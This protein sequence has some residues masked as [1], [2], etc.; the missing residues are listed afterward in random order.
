MKHIFLF[1]IIAL[2][3]FGAVIIS[4]V[5]ELNEKKTEA[6]IGIEKIDIGMSGFVVHKIDEEHRTILKNCVVTNYDEVAKRATIKMSEYKFVEN[7]AL[8]KGKWEV[9]V[10]DDVVLAFGYNRGLLIAPNEEIYYR[11]TK[12]TKLQWVHPDIFASVLS[13]M[14]HPTPMKSDFIKMS[15][16]MSVGLVFVYLD[17]RVFTLDAKSFKILSIAEAKLEQKNTLLP[18]YTRVPEIKAAWWGEGSGRVKKYEP[19]YYEL[20]IKANSKNKE[21]YKIVENADKEIQK[22]LKK[23]DIEGDGN[24][25]KKTF[26]LF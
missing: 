14:G 15:E 26:R 10:G 5:V 13:F 17:G 9:Q 8:P 18:F 23:F 25:R 11:I 4:Q 6:K 24:D 12:N 1:F 7:S 2:K 20:I 21:L 16:S 19:F 22:L 3:L